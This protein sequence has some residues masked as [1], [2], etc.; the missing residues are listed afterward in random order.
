MKKMLC[1]EGKVWEFEGVDQ[2]ECHFLDVSL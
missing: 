2:I 1:E